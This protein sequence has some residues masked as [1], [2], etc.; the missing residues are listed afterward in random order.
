MGSAS[1]SLVYAAAGMAATTSSATQHSAAHRR[2]NSILG[3]LLVD[4]PK[5]TARLPAANFTVAV[6]RAAGQLR[7]PRRHAGA[8]P[9]THGVAGCA[10]GDRACHARRAI[11]VEHFAVPSRIRSLRPAELVRLDLRGAGHR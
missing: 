11:R 1:R 9:V 10:I 4:P 5:R 7:V 2:V 8:A 3:N 6:A